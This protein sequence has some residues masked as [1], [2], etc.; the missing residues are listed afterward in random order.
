MRMIAFFACCLLIG[1]P[2]FAECGTRGG[3]GYRAPSGRCVGWV[4]I[5]RTCGNPPTTKCKAEIVAPG[6]DGAADHGQKAW[7]AGKDARS[8][9]GRSE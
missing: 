2:A 5:G 3:P 1:D 6:S 8:K 4:D 7:D 9:A